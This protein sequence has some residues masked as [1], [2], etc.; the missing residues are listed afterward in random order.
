M[1]LDGALI[2]WSAGAVVGV[3]FIVAAVGKIARPDEW[4]ADASSLGVGRMLAS[5]VPIVEMLVGSLLVVGV[6]DPWMPLVAL[7]VLICFTALLARFVGREDAPACACFG[8]RSRR[9][10]GVGHLVRNGL[11]IALSVVAGV[12]S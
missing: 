11:L 2:G 5:A 9:P 1:A 4:R 12:L 7:A 10:I 3:V 8:R 6:W